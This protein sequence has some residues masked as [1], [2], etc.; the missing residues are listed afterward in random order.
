MRRPQIAP[1]EQIERDFRESDARTPLGTTWTMKRALLEIAVASHAHE[2][3]GAFAGR[4]YVDTTEDHVARALGLDALLERLQRQRWIDEVRAYVEAA[5]QGKAPRFAVNEIGSPLFGI[6]MFRW[7]DVEPRDVLKGLV[8]GGLRDNPVWRRKA[9]EKY[10]IEIGYGEAHPV[11]IE[12]MAAAGLSG[13]RLAHEGLEGSLED[14]RRKGIVLPDDTPLGG[15][16][17]SLYIRYQ[18]GPG[19]SDDAA[20]LAA[21]LLYGVG[22]ALGCYLADAID[23]IE[24]YTPVHADQDDQLAQMIRERAPDLGVTDDMVTHLTF[25][26]STPPDLLD[27]LPDSTM[28]RFLRLDSATD[29]TILESHFL[30]LLGRPYDTLEMGRHPLM[31]NEAL[32]AYV[33]DTVNQHPLA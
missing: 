13:D 20:V 23:T 15:D 32:Y 2:G 19:A 9:Q 30:F 3:H 33:Q 26:A 14:L 5:I 25:L 21:G 12:K 6:G 10:R 1:P 11:D 27:S 22:T 31:N 4:R 7:L 16:V 8:L 17:Q 18:T 29:Q 24:K 28:R